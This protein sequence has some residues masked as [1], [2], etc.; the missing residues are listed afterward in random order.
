[1]PPPMPPVP[2]IL[3]HG[4][5]KV[6]DDLHVW[7]LARDPVPAGSRDHASRVLPPSLRAWI[8]P[9][10][11]D[12]DGGA[13]RW[14]GPVLHFHSGMD[15]RYYVKT[16]EPEHLSWLD[17]RPTLTDDD[18]QRILDEVM[19]APRKGPRRAKD[20]AWRLFGAQ[21]DRWYEA[22][23]AVVPLRA[24]VVGRTVKGPGTT[25]HRQAL[26]W[27]RG[28]LDELV[29]VSAT[30]PDEPDHIYATHGWGPAVA[31]ALLSATPAKKLPEAQRRSLLR[32]TARA[33]LSGDAEANKL[34]AA[35]TK[36]QR[37]Q[38]VAELLREG[39]DLSLAWLAGR[40]THSL[41]MDDDVYEAARG[42][43]RG[44]LSGYVVD[45]AHDR[46]IAPAKGVDGQAWLRRFVEV[47]KP[48]EAP[49]LVRP[50][51]EHPDDRLAHDDLASWRG[52]VSLAADEA[53]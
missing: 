49:H 47:A 50:A 48:F 51:T 13:L 33:G 28:H 17:D 31:R 40:R 7:L 25:R 19:D 23:H 37:P 45:Q 36:R 15:V 29:H 12:G 1:M 6:P 8:Q 9:E 38:V 44:L 14:H 20:E 11:P 22:V 34:L 53:P 26:A 30:L 3:H 32:L 10:P 21:L 41:L 24:V 52:L 35:W 16:L 43:P 4:P 42:M 2:P 27:A 5:P 18:V 39:H 46:R